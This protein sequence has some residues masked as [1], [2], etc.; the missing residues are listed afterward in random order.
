[1]GVSHNGTIT[2]NVC[3]RTRAVSSQVLRRTEPEY[4]SNAGAPVSSL[5]VEIMLD[6]EFAQTEA[7][8]DCAVVRVGRMA[9]AE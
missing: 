8:G 6:A 2:T 9:G 4:F 3:T 7:S 1:M 5:L